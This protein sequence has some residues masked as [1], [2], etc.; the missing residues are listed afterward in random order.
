MVARDDSQCTR[1]IASQPSITRVVLLGSQ[2]HIDA[3]TDRLIELQYKIAVL[4]GELVRSAPSAVDPRLPKA[5][6]RLRREVKQRGEELVF[7]RA[8]SDELASGTTPSEDAGT[9]EDG[10]DSTTRDG[11][12]D[13]EEPALD[14][15]GKAQLQ[16]PSA[17]ADILR[18]ANPNSPSS[19]SSS[20]SGPDEVLGE[21]L[22]VT[23]ETFGKLR[24]VRDY[25]IVKK[26]RLF[27]RPKV[28]QY[29]D[30]G[31]LHRS[32][33]ELKTS[34]LELFVDLLYVGVF[35]KAGELMI[36][37][38]TWDTFNHLALIVFPMLT[39]FE[40]YTS[41]NNTF[42]H[43]DMFYKIHTFIVVAFIAVMG[44]TLTNSFNP[45]AAANTSATFLWTYVLARAYLMIIPLIVVLVFERRFIK[46]YLPAVFTRPLALIPFIAAASIPAGEGKDSLRI[47]LWWFGILMDAIMPAGT[48]ALLLYGGFGGRSRR[49]AVNIEH[50]AE[51]HGALFVIALGTVAVSFL[52]NFE[53]NSMSSLIGLMIL[54]LLL[55]V[56][57][58]HLYFRAEGAQHYMHALRRVWYTGVAWT[59]IHMPLFVVTITLGSVM[60]AMLKAAFSSRDPVIISEEVPAA[61][62]HG[63]VVVAEEGTG[64]E[65]ATGGSLFTLDPSYKDLFSVSL[66]LVFLC[67]AVL[68]I[69]HV[70]EHEDPSEAEAIR[71]D[72]FSHAMALIRFPTI[73][74]HRSRRRH[75]HRRRPN[76][77]HGLRTASL[78]VAA[79]LVV[80][81]GIGAGKVEWSA[82]TWFGGAAAVSVVLV[83][84]EEWGRLRQRKTRRRAGEKQK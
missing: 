35:F 76:L 11:A 37:S 12:D 32:P 27:R 55:G 60:S 80:A 83:A 42:H 20:T 64:S 29:F 65:A 13:D 2:Q 40:A 7:L 84:I 36:N 4:D 26:E 82:E 6:E 14:S 78:V 66:A 52:Y 18:E 48:I 33:E 22:H 15:N 51:R 25:T 28:R 61:V 5:L 16:V 62:A 81:V 44:N 54:A 43:E 9:T 30:D 17:I 41:H 58:N 56:N 23:S 53:S 46:N 49:L 24:K 8:N 67:F 70:E 63:R 45:I 57:L 75:H 73:G 77:S 59:F 38:Q 3:V 72:T 19:S 31:I 69:L 71:A 68:R 21:V 1:Y 10:G 34:W 50:M 74:N 47:G 39:H 79:V